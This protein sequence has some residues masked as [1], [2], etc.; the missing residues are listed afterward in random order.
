VRGVVWWLCFENKKRAKCWP[1]VAGKEQWLEEGVRTNRTSD[2]VTALTT[3]QIHN[4]S[5]FFLSKSQKNKPQQR[6]YNSNFVFVNESR[7]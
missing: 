3:L 4:F 6:V 7:D 1:W 2:L 5:H